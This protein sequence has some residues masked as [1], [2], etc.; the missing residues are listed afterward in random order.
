MDRIRLDPQHPPLWRDADTV[1]FG[2]DAVAVVRLEGGWGDRLIHELGLGI[3][4]ASFDVVAH[5]CGATLPQAR[6]LRT[7]LAPVLVDE[8]PELGAHLVVPLDFDAGAGLRLRDALADAGVD[9]D[10]APQ[11]S[12]AVVLHRGVA[13]SAA[14]SRLVHDDRPHLPVAFDEGGATVGPFVIPGRTPC[15][16]CRDEH[17]RAAD[18][19]WAAVH[20]QLIDRHPGRIP[21]RSIAA[22]A[23]AIAELLTERDHSER[24]GTARV[25]RIS[26]DGARSS[27]TVAFHAE[28]RCRSLR[29]T[30]TPSAAPVRLP[31]TSSPTAFARRA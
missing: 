25:I 30:G 5:R 8:Q 19:A 11:R 13:P 24:E 1:Q 23:D 17:D 28:C 6:A 16:A 22:A 7:L 2:V 15:L 29:G 31:A 4:R 26:A 3:P 12:P 20:S 21:L 10:R 27:R 18:P 14:A 9:A